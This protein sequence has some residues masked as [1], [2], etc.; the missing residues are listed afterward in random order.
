MVLNQFWRLKPQ[1]GPEVCSYFYE[2]FELKK[3][4][5]RNKAA[6]EN[7]NASHHTKTECVILIQ[8][9]IPEQKKGIIGTI[10]NI[11]LLPLGTVYRTGGSEDNW[12]FI[13]CDRFL[14]R[15]TDQS[16]VSWSKDF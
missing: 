1:I 15:F 13:I 5:S 2:W 10:T 16:H 7:G 3:N 9:Y 12:L 11:F 14:K 4:Q 8:S 6:L